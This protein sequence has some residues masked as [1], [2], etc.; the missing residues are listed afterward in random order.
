MYIKNNGKITVVWLNTAIQAYI[1][2]VM[3]CGS[4]KIVILKLLQ[5]LNA[6]N[7]ELSYHR[8]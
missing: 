4:D 8:T 1:L 2:S 6:K 3:T 7:E 5:Y